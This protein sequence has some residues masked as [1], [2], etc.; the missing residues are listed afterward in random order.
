MSAINLTTDHDEVRRRV[1]DLGG[2]PVVVVPAL[3]LGAVWAGGA[4]VGSGPGP[5]PGSR[6]RSATVNA[7]R[8]VV[9]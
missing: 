6:A 7:V 4:F 1:E 5:K 8:D 9:R 2:R 3:V